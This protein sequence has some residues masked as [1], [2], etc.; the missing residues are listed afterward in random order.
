[1]FIDLAHDTARDV[2]DAVL[3]H[4]LPHYLRWIHGSDKLH[5]C[6]LPAVLRQLEQLLKQCVP[7]PMLPE[8]VGCPCHILSV[9]VLVHLI[10][11]HLYACLLFAVAC[12][13]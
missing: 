8:L 2:Q 5:A 3:T 7:S 10:V 1:M 4:L 13:L 11:M 9:L 6:L 12:S